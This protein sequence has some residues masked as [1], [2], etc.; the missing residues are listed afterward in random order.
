ML[1]LR[2]WPVLSC[3]HFVLRDMHCWNICGSGCDCLRFVLAR[4]LLRQQRC[5]LLQELRRWSVQDPVEG[6]VVR[7]VRC[8]VVCHGRGRHHLHQLPGER[9][10]FGGVNFVYALPSRNSSRC[11]REFLLDHGLQRR[12]V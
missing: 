4:Y 10:L 5:R 3:A 2:R 9:F 11:R 6:G 12:L 7:A 8:G 1:E